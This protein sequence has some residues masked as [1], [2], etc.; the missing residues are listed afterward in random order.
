[1]S[2]FKL[3]KKCGATKT[4]DSFHRNKFS[5]DGRDS[6]CKECKNGYY[7]AHRDEI[8]AERKTYAQANREII[9][10][11]KRVYR[12][13]NPEA[14]RESNRKYYKK[15]KNIISHKSRAYYEA[16][17]DW[18]R[19]RGKDYYERNK[20]R[21]ASYAKIYYSVNREY[22][23]AR[24]RRWY[25]ENRERL[26]EQSS[27]YKAKKRKTDPHFLMLERVRARIKNAIKSKWRTTELLGCTGKEAYEHLVSK[28]TDGMTEEAFMDG[29]IHIDHIKPCASFDLTDP[30]QQKECFHYTNLQPL[31][32]GDNLSK[33]AK[34]IN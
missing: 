10:E 31:W 17:K 27:D 19:E 32:A 3:C 7:Q 21:I 20:E 1:M 8:L 29:E 23:K 12:Q 11:R 28:F 16:N 18:I 14:Y 13:R 9:A 2:S 33:G 6:R 22:I 34:I 4:L 30:Q 25:M 26:I 24:T 5:A 15:N